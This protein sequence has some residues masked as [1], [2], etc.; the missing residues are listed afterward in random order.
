[1]REHCAT[2]CASGV[3][4]VREETMIRLPLS[5]TRALYIAAL[6]V[7]GAAAGIG[8]ADN[9]VRAGLAWLL[10]A[11][12]CVVAFKGSGFVTNLLTAAAA[13][14]LFALVVLVQAGSS[15]GSRTVIV[16]LI[17]SAGALLA[18]PFLLLPFST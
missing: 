5:L 17:V 10:L 11:L 1:M 16:S 6:G 8:L 18:T 12:I 14:V 7:I 13:A 2:A 3:A 9:S 15:A 4:P